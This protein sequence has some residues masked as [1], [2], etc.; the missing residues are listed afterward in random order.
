MG[1]NNLQPH[2]HAKFIKAWADGYKIEERCLFISDKRWKIREHPL[3]EKDKEYRIYDP[4]REVKEAC[5]RGEIIQYQ[6]I[7]D[8]RWID[9]YEKAKDISWDT[10]NFKWRIKPKE[11]FKVGDWVITT[12]YIPFLKI[13]NVFRITEVKNDLYICESINDTV[14]LTVE[15]I[16]KATKQ[17]VLNAPNY[18]GTATNKDFPFEEGDWI[19][20]RAAKETKVLKFNGLTPHGFIVMD[21]LAKNHKEIHKYDWYYAKYDW[22]YA[23]KEEIEEYVLKLREQS[24]IPENLKEYPLTPEE[25]FETYKLKNYEPFTWEDREQLRDK[26]VVHKDFR[27]EEKIISFNKGGTAWITLSEDGRINPI[28][29]FEDYIFLD[30]SP[31]AKLKK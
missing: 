30:S 2:I 9:L 13:G 29:L 17:E 16:K 6:E 19:I 11:K 25:C 31:C 28:R 18:D 23:T 1:K 8:K 24:N 14:S 12:K 21:L 22:Y 26:W 4:L 10:T 7:G 15:N 3:W 27:N 5:K 20:D